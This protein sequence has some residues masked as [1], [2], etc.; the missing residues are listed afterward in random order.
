MPKYSWHCLLRILPK[1]PMRFFLAQSTADYSHC[2]PYFPSILV[3]CPC[4]AIR[5]YA[6]EIGSSYVDKFAWDILGQNFC[7]RH[8]R[9]SGQYQLD[10]SPIHSNYT[11]T[12]SMYYTRTNAQFTLNNLYCLKI[13][14]ALWNVIINLWMFKEIKLMYFAINFRAWWSLHILHSAPCIV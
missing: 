12:L 3:T 13:C 8:S 6:A 10:W 11:L 2:L 5:S 9:P 7:L 14:L 4:L 1:S